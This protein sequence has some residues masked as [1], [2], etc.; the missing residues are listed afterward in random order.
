MYLLKELTILNRPYQVHQKLL[1][2]QVN[3]AQRNSFPGLKI[4]PPPQ[5]LALRQ[6]QN[7]YGNG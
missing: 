3:K 4:D 5:L 2:I 6:R 7:L 1:Y